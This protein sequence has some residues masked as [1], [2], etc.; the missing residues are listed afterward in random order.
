METIPA[1]EA[2]PAEQTYGGVARTLHWLVF[3][4]VGVQ[5]GIGWTMPE[6]ETDTPQQGLVDWH[7]S[8]GSTILAVVIL[9]LIW[10]ITHPTPNQDNQLKLL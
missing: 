6:I 4:L 10:R 2:N 3:A 9:R 5:F 7:L 8:V 1:P